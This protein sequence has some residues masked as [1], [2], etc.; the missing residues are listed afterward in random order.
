MRPL[1]A[2]HAGDYLVG[3]HIEQN[4]PRW[5]V[6]VPSKDTGIDLLV[7]DSRNRR[8]VSLQVKFSKDFNPKQPILL[9]NKLM[10]VGMVDTSTGKNPEVRSRFLVVCAAVIH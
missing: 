6:W 8:T 1:F 3:S 5:Y 7:T 10:S 2:V 4:Y 9:Q